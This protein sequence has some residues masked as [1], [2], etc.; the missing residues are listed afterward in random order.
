MWDTLEGSVDSSLSQSSSGVLKGLVD[1][2]CTQS[3]SD[4]DISCTQSSSDA[5]RQQS[6]T[7][8]INNI[9]TTTMTVNTNPP[10]VNDQRRGRSPTTRT[11]NTSRLRSLTP[12]EHDHDYDPTTT[13]HDDC[14]VHAQ[15]EQTMS[16]SLQAAKGVGRASGQPRVSLSPSLRMTRQ[17][18]ME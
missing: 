5:Q 3:S 1:I 16:S 2:S 12:I 8:H 4:V 7:Q 11:V 14:T 15:C 9:T 6:T 10:T 13:D 18:L 17:D